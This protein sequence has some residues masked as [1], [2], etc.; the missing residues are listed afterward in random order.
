M[1]ATSF[2]KQVNYH[3]KPMSSS[4][5]RLSSETPLQASSHMMPLPLMSSCVRLPTHSLTDTTAAAIEVQ[6]TGIGEEE[7]LLISC[8]DSCEI[9]L[10]G[11]PC[12]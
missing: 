8:E 10:W 2:C 5:P 7:V 4:Q 6:R 11:S 9:Q 1:G 12:R 3:L